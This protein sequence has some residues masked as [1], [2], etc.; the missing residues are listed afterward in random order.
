MGSREQGSA[1]ML[2]EAL[3]NVWPEWLKL[4]TYQDIRRSVLDA[5]RKAISQRRRYVRRYAIFCATFPYALASTFIWVGDHTGLFPPSTVQQQYADIARWEK[6]LVRAGA[7]F[8]Q[9]CQDLAVVKPNT[10]GA[11]NGWGEQ[12]E[13]AQEKEIEALRDELKAFE[14]A[15]AAASSSVLGALIMLISSQAFSRLWLR[16]NPSHFSRTVEDTQ[17]VRRAYLLVMATTSFIPT[18]IGACVLVLADLISRSTTS[19]FLVLSEWLT[20]TGF[21]PFAVCGVVGSYRLNHVLLGETNWGMGRTWWV[22]LLSNV[23]TL[24]IISFL[25]APAVLLLFLGFII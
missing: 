1:S 3:H 5:P 21:L 10:A 8:R 19:A 16:F 23:V 14:T 22:M 20:I 7:R 4:G 18:C 11:C 15:K 6:E 12:Y 25:I 9:S 17:R 24:A 13:A 2:Y